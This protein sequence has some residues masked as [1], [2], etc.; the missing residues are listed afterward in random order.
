MY[1]A[2]LDE[3]LFIPHTFLF[4]SLFLIKKMYV[5]LRPPDLLDISS[6]QCDSLKLFSVVLSEAGYFVLLAQLAP[7][8]VFKLFA[9]ENNLE[10]LT[11]WL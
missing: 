1:L 8:I 4:L 3:K 9:Y 6:L 10:F 2:V 11:R 5:V 7:L